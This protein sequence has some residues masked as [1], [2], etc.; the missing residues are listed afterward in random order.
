MIF[1]G[2]ADRGY[3][4]EEY[5]EKQNLYFDYV[6][7]S[8][9]IQEQVN[10]ILTHQK[11]D[12]TIFD[13]EQYTDEAEVIT[14]WVW[15]ICNTNCSKPIILASG[16]RSF[17]RIIT[18]LAESGVKYFILGAT[19][20]D[21]KDQLEKCLNGFYDANGIEFIEDVKKEQEEIEEQISSNCTTIAVTGA[22][23]RI[24]TTTQAIQFIRYI[25]LC[26]KKACYIQMNGNDYIQS[27]RTWFDVEEDEEIGKVTYQ[28][29]DH[30]YK[31]DKIREIMQK[32][33]DFYIYDYGVYF[34]TDF[35][36]VS[37][38]EKDKQIFVVGSDQSEMQH[39]YNII[40]SAFYDMVNYIYNFTSDAD[41][42]AIL[43]LMEEKA[44]KTYFSTY[45]PDKYVFAPNDIYA[46]IVPIE[47]EE[48]P[49]QNES[50]KKK[51]FRRSRK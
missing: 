3:F 20:S 47:E 30:Y 13:V 38:Q 37:F 18:E 4:V 32:N 40:Q 42:P 14:D 44:E 26:G 36:R 16:Y 51:F 21:M 27:L 7:S 10:P 45:V 49:V 6:E 5:C 39:T 1:V 17:A 28:G 22:C 23:K 46:E 29:V 48:V 12:Y 8:L 33:Y 24:G 25:Q 43:E 15:K 11:Q 50:K 31:L 9:S 41:K 19:L 34:D 35:N 2:R